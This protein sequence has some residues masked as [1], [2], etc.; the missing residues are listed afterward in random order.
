M[1]ILKIFTIKMKNIEVE[2]RSFISEEKY[3]ELIDF[4]KKNWEFLWKDYQETFYFNGE[5][6]LRIQKN[7]NYS[8][9]WM[10]EWNIHDEARKEIEIKVPKDDFEKLENLFL[11]LGYDI[12]I[13]WY[14]LRNDFKWEWIRISLD[15]TK[16]Y[17]YI[18][19]LE[20]MS[21]IEEKDKNSDYLKK[22]FVE[23][24]I[25]ITS[26]DEFTQKYKY[27]KENWHELTK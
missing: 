17:W 6:D 16:W 23:L 13:K 5:K 27:Y 19:E 1:V 7:E 18:I 24:W 4:F 3:K 10:K 12:E 25:N 15:H 22:K 8:K 14:R 2:I 11:W 9:I 26:K 21:S 20:I